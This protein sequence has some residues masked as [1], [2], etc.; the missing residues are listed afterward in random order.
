MTE[1][2]SS[3]N[4][5]IFLKVVVMC[6]LRTLFHMVEKMLLLPNPILDFQTI[7]ITKWAKRLSSTFSIII[8]IV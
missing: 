4:S 5:V 6:R 2:D 3:N 8:L 1:G 7:N